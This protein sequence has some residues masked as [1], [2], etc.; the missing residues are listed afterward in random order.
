MNVATVCRKQIA[1]LFIT[2]TRLF[3]NLVGPKCNN[4][5]LRAHV[6][7]LCLNFEL[8]NFDIVV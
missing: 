8:A 3:L 5:L 6:S 4:I 1:V 7:F 2:I